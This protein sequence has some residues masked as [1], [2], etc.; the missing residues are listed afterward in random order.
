MI[1]EKTASLAG[2]VSAKTQQVMAGE[3]THEDAEYLLC[4]DFEIWCREF[5]YYKG[6]DGK[7]AQGLPPN[8]LQLRVIDHYRHCQHLRIPCLILILKP[9]QRGAST[10]AEAV[11][12]HHMR[13]Y[14]DLNGVLMGDVQSTSDKVFEMFR[15]YAEEDN[16]PWRDGQPN[17][18]K[19]LNLADE[20][21]LA[22]GS[23]WWK[24]TAGSTNAGRS[25]TVQVLHMDEVAYF[26]NTSSKDPTTAVLG[27]FYKDGAQSLGFATSTA[28][29]PS[30]WFHDTWW[31]KN[32]WKKIFAAWY[33]F[34][35]C[36]TKFANSEERNEF[37][38]SMT[39]D[40][41][42]EQALYKVSL[43]QLN[44][45]RAKIF[46]DYK[47]DIGKFQQEFPSS[48]EGA[49]LASSRMRFDER[50]ITE[51][52]AWSATN[53]DRQKGNL[54]LQTERG[55][56]TWQPD[57]KGSV[58]RW[59]EPIIGCRYLI[60]IDTCSG[61]DQQTSGT[62]SDPDYHS[63]QAWRQ[64]YI[65]RGGKQQDAALVALHHSREDT[66]ILCEIAA[67]MAYYYGNCLV[68]PEVNGQGGFYTVKVLVNKY[69][70][71][72]YRRSPHT[73]HRKTQTEDE[74]ISAYG[75][76]TDKLTRKVIIDAAVPFIRL[77]QLCI[78]APEVWMEFRTFIITAS[79]SCEAAPSKHDDH[80][81]ST[82]IGAYNLGAATEYRLG[83]VRGIDLNRLG[84]DPNYMTADGFRRTAV[85]Y[86]LRG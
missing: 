72:V 5:A 17:I 40:E 83:M 55:P 48:P 80:V 56:A 24:E 57:A 27:S 81:I 14:P 11:I 28:A 60:S 15:R 64:S 38:K 23:K 51:C 63:V 37:A 7:K 34:P 61:E 46:G 20:I 10:I 29:G 4:L 39:D 85:T 26:P 36:S 12:Y 9:R 1:D 79:G 53:D 49:F 2:D 62:T 18:I 52:L 16:F 66:D 13:K 65:D 35:E 33:E 21:T 75:W 77:Q 32:N 31:G 82:C 68:V 78:K 50:S 86:K 73:T 45:R 30:G 71:N 84:R 76:T 8:I 54:V 6:I 69:R 47:G 43:E 19:G 67:G 58:S 25:G 70:L 41:T 74:K 22:T 42:L 59:E 44:W 3:L